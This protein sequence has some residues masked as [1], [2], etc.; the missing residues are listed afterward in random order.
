[1]SKFSTKAMPVSPYDLEP[2]TMVPG[3]PIPSL[4]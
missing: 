4:A 2:G 3:R 1:M